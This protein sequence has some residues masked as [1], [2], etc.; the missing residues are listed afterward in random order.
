MKEMGADSKAPDWAKMGFKP[1]GKDSSS[2]KRKAEEV[3]EEDDSKPSSKGKGKP[4]K[5]AKK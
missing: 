4:A 3:E 2:S 5:K 1:E